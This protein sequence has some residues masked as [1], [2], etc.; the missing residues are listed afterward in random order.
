[1]QRCLQPRSMFHMILMMISRIGT[2]KAFR[3]EYT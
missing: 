2:V 3:I 1:M